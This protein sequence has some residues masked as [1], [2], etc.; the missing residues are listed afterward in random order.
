ME[1]RLFVQLVHLVSKSVLG[2]KQMAAISVLLVI[3]VNQE[4]LT[5][6]SRLAPRVPTVLTVSML[7]VLKVRQAMLFMARV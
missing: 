2:I 1:F 6:S 7:S 5:I 3:T 4:L